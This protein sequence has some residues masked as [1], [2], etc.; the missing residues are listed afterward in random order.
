M[1][2]GNT[3]A[4]NARAE[5]F[6][7]DFATATLVI[8]AG[9]TTLATHTLAGFGAAATGVITASAIATATIAATGT[10][11]SATLTAGTSVYTLTVGTSGTDVIVNSTAYVSGGTSTI[12]SL[13]VTFPA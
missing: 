1:A 7:T 2:T 5:D 9:G 8:L 6:S 11:N 3:A 10:A 13:A 12:N 4:R